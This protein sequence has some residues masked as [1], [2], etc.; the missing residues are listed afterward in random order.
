MDK[1][2]QSNLCQNELINLIA[3][4]DTPVFLQKLSEN[5][6]TKTEK[7]II[8]FILK[9]YS[10]KEI[11]NAVNRSIHTVKNHVKNI[12]HKLGVSRRY[13]IILYVINEKIK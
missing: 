2:K 8:I 5:N 6:I 12:F 9:G 3:K 4:V 10:N 13:S 1:S 7:Q 11:S